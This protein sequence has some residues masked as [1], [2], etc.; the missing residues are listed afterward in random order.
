MDLGF[1][2]S[3]CKACLASYYAIAKDKA[4]GKRIYQEDMESAIVLLSD[5]TVS[6]DWQGYYEIADV[7][8]HLGNDLN[9]LSAWSLVT[10]CD[11][12]WEVRALEFEDEPARSLAKDLLESMGPSCPPGTSP[13]AQFEFLNKEAATRNSS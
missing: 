4:K 6:N 1:A 10:P 2:E 12:D 8:M 5:S 3:V 7:L 9:A 13:T 11:V